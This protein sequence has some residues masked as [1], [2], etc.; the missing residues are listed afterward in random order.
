MSGCR[1]DV[2]TVG[3]KEKNEVS[4][5]NI[6]KDVFEVEQ[7]GKEERAC[8]VLAVAEGGNAGH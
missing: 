1:L 6:E 3:A 8:K 2:K 7:K 4:G 5:S